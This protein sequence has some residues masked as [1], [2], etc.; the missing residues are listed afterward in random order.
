MAHNYAGIL[1]ALSAAPETQID[2]KITARLLILAE[3]GAETE[4]SALAEDLKTI[5]DE[6]AYFSLASDFAMQAMHLVW[7][8]MLNEKHEPNLQ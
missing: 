4:T 2:S 8:Q 3:A 5:L 6:C 1:K 7:Q